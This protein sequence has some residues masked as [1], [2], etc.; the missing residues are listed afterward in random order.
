MLIAVLLAVPVVMSGLVA[1][2]FKT[3]AQ[4]V[5][6]AGWFVPGRRMLRTNLGRARPDEPSPVRPAQKPSIV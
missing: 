2:L 4:L 6:V 1:A 5:R 3:V